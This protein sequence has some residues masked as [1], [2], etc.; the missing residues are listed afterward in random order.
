MLKYDVVW[1]F[2]PLLPVIACFADSRYLNYT[3]GSTGEQEHALRRDVRDLTLGSKAG[4]FGADCNFRVVP[5][6]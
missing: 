3:V 5:G 4:V 6:G 1:H 2:N